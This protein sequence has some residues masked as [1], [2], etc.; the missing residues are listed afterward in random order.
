MSVLVASICPIERGLYK[1]LFA[2]RKLW[3]T[4]AVKRGQPPAIVQFDEGIVAPKQYVGLGNYMDIPE[5]AMNVALDFINNA[6]NLP[7]AKPPIAMPGIWMVG[8]LGENLTFQIVGA[9]NSGATI[10][11]LDRPHGLS[12]PL[13]VQISGA[14]NFWAVINGTFRASPMNETSVVINVDSRNFGEFSNGGANSQLAVTQH[15]SLEQ[16]AEV[17]RPR[18]DQWLS[19]ILNNARALWT[20]E[21]SNRHIIP[22]HHIAAEWF[23]VEEDWQASLST[24]STL[25]VDCPYCKKRVERALICSNCKNV[26][27]VVG[28]AKMELEKEAAIREEKRR[29]KEIRDEED[30]KLREINIAAAN[31]ARLARQAEE[32]PEETPVEA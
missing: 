23:G 29:L 7:F 14:S 21:K 4:P 1:H 9:S 16:E 30:R 32:K 10:L 8:S 26:I 20:Q 15:L 27:D 24:D 12:G 28:Y 6:V 19:R 31:A 13:D 2:P 18:Q 3:M 25:M 22:L 11:Q 5:T 17:M